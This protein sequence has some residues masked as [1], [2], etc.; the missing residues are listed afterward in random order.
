VLRWGV[1]LGIAMIPRSSNLER[2]AENLDVFDF[3]LT[4]DEVAAISALDTGAEE[5]ADS[6]TGGH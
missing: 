3:A 1:E 5:R 6:D 4:D 2:L